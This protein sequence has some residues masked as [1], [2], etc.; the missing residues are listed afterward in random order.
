MCAAGIVTVE[1]EI[2]RLRRVLIHAPGAEWDLVPCGPGVLERFLIEDI[3]VL[4]E[5][6]REHGL[7][8]QVLHLFIGEEN[9]LEVETLLKDVCAEEANRHEIVGAISALDGLGLAPTAALLDSRLPP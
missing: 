6:Q 4:G 5:A 8:A 7:L 3:F 2:G 1:S 9:V